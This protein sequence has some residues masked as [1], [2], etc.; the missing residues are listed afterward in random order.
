[1]PVLSAHDTWTAN[2]TI[3]NGAALSDAFDFSR[4]ASLIVTL[5]ATWT[6]ASIAFHVSNSQ[7]GTY[8]PLYDDDGN[9][10]QIDSPT[11]SKAYNAPAALAGAH[12]VKLWSQNGSGTNTNQA[13][14]RILGL[15]FKS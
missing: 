5:P 11:A 9:L 4:F 13:A 15:D 12:W 6:A 2:A 8:V 3:A 10:A 7:G 14:E 1:M